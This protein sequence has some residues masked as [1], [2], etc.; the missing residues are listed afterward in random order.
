MV[1]CFMNK[2][3]I[4]TGWH[5]YEENK[6]MYHLWETHRCSFLVKLRPFCGE[7]LALAMKD[8]E[9]HFNTAATKGYA[10]LIVKILKHDVL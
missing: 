3:R 2:T 6:K 7:F 8:F 1:R 5:L 9:V 4:G 10:S